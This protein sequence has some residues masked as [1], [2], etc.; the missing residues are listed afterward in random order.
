MPNFGHDRLA[1][2]L[3][4]ALFRFVHTWTNLQLIADRPLNMATRYFTIFPEDIV[5]VWTVS[6]VVMGRRE[7]VDWCGDGEEGVWTVSGVKG[8]GVVYEV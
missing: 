3:F 6:G 2:V 5:P 1:L 4:E 7:G 8:E